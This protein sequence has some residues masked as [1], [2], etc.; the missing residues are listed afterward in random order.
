[1]NDITIELFKYLQRLQQYPLVNHKRLLFPELRSDLLH[2][3]AGE[4]LTKITDDGELLI[5]QSLYSAWIEKLKTQGFDMAIEL[6]KYKVFLCPE[7]GEMF[8]QQPDCDI[9]LCPVCF[10][11]DYMKP[12]DSCINPHK[13][14]LSS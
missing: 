12:K 8:I 7:R 1:M 3:I 10:N 9:S 13:D 5:P 11:K 2:F 14:Y 4:T 6:S